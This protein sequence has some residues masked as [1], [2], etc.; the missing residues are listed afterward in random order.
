MS[1]ITKIEMVEAIAEHLA[2]EG[3]RLTNLKKASV[4]QLEELVVKYG[5][6]INAFVEQ[7]NL[8]KKLKKLWLKKN[9]E[10]RIRQKAEKDKEAEV[11]H[12]EG[13]CDIQ[14]YYINGKADYL[15][16]KEQKKQKEEEEEDTYIIECYTD[17]DRCRF[18]FNYTRDFNWDFKK[19]VENEKIIKYECVFYNRND[20]DTAVDMTQYNMNYKEM[21][22]KYITNGKKE[23]EDLDKKIREIEDYVRENYAVV[24]KKYRMEFTTESLVEF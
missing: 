18:D 13:L 8:R 15:L 16:T 7:R 23:E 9:K 21:K 14:K 12:I 1:K 4:G 22:W 5:I 11:L 6:D 20:F 17:E 3:K 10:E 24:L 19:V 2:E